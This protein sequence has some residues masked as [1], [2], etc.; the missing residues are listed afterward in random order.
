MTHKPILCLDFDGVIHS[1][2]SGWQGAAAI[3]DPPVPGAMEFL[4]EAV[5]HFQVAIF[6]SRSN[7]E[8]GVEAMRDYLLG[9]LMRTETLPVL[10]RTGPLESAAHFISE[11]IGF[12][13]EKPSAMVTIDDRAITFTGQWPDM[14]TLLAFQPWNKKPKTEQA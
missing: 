11:H 4:I 2:T 1:Y 14:K 12:P 9:H 3:P 5:E 10:D 7:Q 6:S 8:G 13:T